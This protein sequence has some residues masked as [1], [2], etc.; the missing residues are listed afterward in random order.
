MSA[1]VRRL[2]LVSGDLSLPGH[3]TLTVQREGRHVN[4]AWRHGRGGPP[5]APPGHAPLGG[6]DE[7]VHAAEWFETPWPEAR[8][9]EPAGGALKLPLP[10]ADRTLGELALVWRNE[11]ERRR[12]APPWIAA[13]ARRLTLLIHR[14]EVRDWAERRLG[15][16][17]LLVGMSRPM[18]HLEGLIEHAAR[19]SLPVLLTGEFGTEKLQLAATIHCGGKRRDQ[20]FVQVNCAEPVD[21]PGDWFERAAGGTLFL[22][23]VDELPRDLLR[24]LPSHMRSHLGQWAPDKDPHDVR[25]VATATQ[26]LRDQVLDGAFSRALLA[27]LD[28]LSI[29]AP[30]LRE[31]VDDLDALVASA[32]QR[33]GFRVEDKQSEA[34]MTACRAH[35]WPE[36][37]FELER[38]VTRLA[39]MTGSRSIGREDILMH[40]PWIVTEP[41]VGL[42]SDQRPAAPRQA[43]ASESERWIRCAVHREEAELER[44]HE[45]LA[46]ALLY[47]GDHYAEPISLGLLARQAHVSESHLSFLFRTALDMPFKGVLGRIRIHKAKEI[48]ASESRRHITEVA[49][50]VGFAD[51]SH[52]EKSF[53]RVVGESPRE[54]RRR[55]AMGREAE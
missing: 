33:H 19:S 54:F 22:N 39:V 36:N 15:R 1:L 43:V 6:V 29:A 37:L 11:A 53:K 18:L 38:V 17:L 30:P 28:M 8:L 35:A 26:D 14:Y 42:L 50:S 16:P 55:A 24:Q 31:R 7:A 12:N 47:L 13:F 4:S 9:D 2:D 20:P 25:I 21:G 10:Y 46:R 3:G 41:A 23:G 49:L 51:L 5:R 48:L 32:L 27:E 40:S 44:L 52:F 45:G 34:L